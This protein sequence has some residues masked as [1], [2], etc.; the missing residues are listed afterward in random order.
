M[1]AE[2]SAPPAQQVL[3]QPAQATYQQVDIENQE[4]LTVA[5]GPWKSGLF[6]CC[7]DPVRC[8]LGFFCPCC[9]T[10]E[11]VMKAAP[12]KLDPLGCVV[13]REQAILWCLAVWL[14]GSG[15]AGTVLF[16]LMVLMMMSFVKK[17]RIEE[18]CLT[19]IVKSVCCMCC[20]QLQVIHHIDKLKKQSTQAPSAYGT[21]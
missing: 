14:V 19:T 20:Y 8:C 11:L 12:F 3:A 4:V 18:G 21:P 7:L 13:L 17:F 1:S 2:P 9:V 6:S 16:I 10:Y 5:P 15:T